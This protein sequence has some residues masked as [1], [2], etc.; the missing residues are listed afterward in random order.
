MRIKLPRGIMGRRRYVAF[1]L[2]PRG[3]QNPPSRSELERAIT[4]A[5]LRLF[6]VLG[7]ADLEFSLKFYSGRSGRG[8]LKTDSR[9]LPHALTILM[10]A[11]AATGPFTL[12]VDA[13]SGTLSGLA[14]K[15]GSPTKTL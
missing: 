15:S 8:V 3:G 7:A 12:E 1:A 4:E 13:V 14:R 5:A 11:A 10:A 9:S 6:G 2:V